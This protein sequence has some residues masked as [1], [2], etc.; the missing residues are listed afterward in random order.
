MASELI[1][2]I[3]WMYSTLSG[4]AMLTESAPGGVW[5][6]DAP[7]GTVMPYIVMLYQP[8][9]SEDKMAFRGVRVLSDLYFEVLAIGPAKVTQTIANAAGRIDE[10]LKVIDPLDIDGGTILSCYRTQPSEA[11]PLIDG[12]TQTNIGGMYRIMLKAS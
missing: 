2:A 11:D 5:R 3:G 9:Q 1:V 4:D 7:P 8:N 12:E 10:L 6:G